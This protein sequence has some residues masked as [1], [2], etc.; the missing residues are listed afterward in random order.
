MLVVTIA[1]QD[2]PDGGVFV[3]KHVTIHAGD[4]VQ[5]VNKADNKMLHNATN[6]DWDTDLLKP[7]ETATIKFPKAG[8]FPYYCLPHKQTMTGTIEVK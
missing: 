5:F 8:T 1:M 2:T 7:G 6:D 4:S 3:P